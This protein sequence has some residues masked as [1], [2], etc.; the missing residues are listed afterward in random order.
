MFTIKPGF[1]IGAYI[2]FTAVISGMGGFWLG[3][4]SNQMVVNSSPKPLSTPIVIPIATPT[5]IVTPTPIPSLSQTTPELSG[6][7]FTMSANGV[8]LEACG[9]PWDYVPPTPLPSDTECLEF[10]ANGTVLKKYIDPWTTSST[11]LASNK[12]ASAEER[13]RIKA[14][15]Q[16]IHQE[17]TQDNYIQWLKVPKMPYAGGINPYIK[18]YSGI[19]GKQYIVTVYMWGADYSP[20][21]QR[22]KEIFELLHSF[23][24]PTPS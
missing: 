21:S 8:V 11:L 16:T 9:G 20:E 6:L 5:L 4:L 10:E 3:K 12:N 24:P 15:L 23:S 1:T 13:A 2:A 19:F 22:L 14:Q 18:L 17:L 7:F